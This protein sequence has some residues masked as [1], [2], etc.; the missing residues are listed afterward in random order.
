MSVDLKKVGKVFA[1]PRLIHQEE[2]VFPIYP[3]SYPQSYPLKRSSRLMN[4][5]GFGR[6]LYGK[7]GLLGPVHR[8]SPSHGNYSS[9]V[10][11]PRQEKA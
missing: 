5:V 11:W 2:G 8:Q 4:L 10:R 3:Q 1:F 9:R 7:S 6:I